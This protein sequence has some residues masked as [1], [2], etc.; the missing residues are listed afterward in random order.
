MAAFATR[1]AAGSVWRSASRAG[2]F[3]GAAACA[4]GRPSPVSVRCARGSRATCCRS[5]RGFGM[6]VGMTID[7]VRAGHR[8]I[9]VELELAHRA[10]GR[11]PGRLCSSRPPARRLRAR[12]P[13]PPVGSRRDDPRH[14]PGHHRHNLLRLRR[15]V[16]ADRTVLSRVSPALPS[17]R[18]GRARSPRIGTVTH[19]VAGEA[20]ADAGVRPG[21]L[22][23]VGDRQPARDRLRLGSRHRRAAA[24]RDRLAGPPHRFA[25]RAS[26]APTVTSRS[27]ALAP[28]SCS[29]PISRPPRSRGCSTTFR[30]CPSA[31]AMAGPCSA[32]STRG[33]RSSS[34]AST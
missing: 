18:L 4:R 22:A 7:A 29:T 28:A 27:S 26:C 1:A 13:R 14:R 24:S 19:A 33:S 12:L 11:T 23:A 6:E 8:V 32:R 31:P 30:A 16:R 34:P 2:R 21:D 17:A 15:A 20:L 25:L 9:E 3:A 10:T 5:P